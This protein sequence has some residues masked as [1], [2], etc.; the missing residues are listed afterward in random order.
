MTTVVYQLRIVDIPVITKSLH[1]YIFIHIIN[2]VNVLQKHHQIIPT[3]VKNKNQE[4][5]TSS[6]KIR[7]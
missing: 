4:L 6:I 7:F 1:L 3:P 2:I 5:R